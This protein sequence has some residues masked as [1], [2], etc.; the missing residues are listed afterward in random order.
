[1]NTNSTAE[2]QCSGAR[3]TSKQTDRLLEKVDQ[4]SGQSLKSTSE[5]S[6]LYKLNEKYALSQDVSAV[7]IGAWGR[8]KKGSWAYTKNSAHKTLNTEFTK[9]KE[10]AAKTIEVI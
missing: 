4:V 1:M 10:K 8:L 6:D 7:L 3:K 9:T 5:G 2:P